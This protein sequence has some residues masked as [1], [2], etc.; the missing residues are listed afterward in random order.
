M[1]NYY[2]CA[3]A[4]GTFIVPPANAGNTQYTYNTLG[5][6][7]GVTYPDGSS[8]TFQY[9]KAGNRTQILGV[10]AAGTPNSNPICTSGSEIAL[11]RHEYSTTIY[12]YYLGLSDPDGDQVR[13]SSS[14][15]GVMT[16][17]GNIVFEGMPTDFYYRVDYTAT[18][19]RGGT[20]SG[21]FEVY[22]DSA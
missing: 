18:D 11:Y 17:A 2:L 10:S 4:I 21:Y 15:M 7:T 1:R 14:S 3:L 20:C 12:P 13:F 5:R 16:A 22:S 9:D 6:V 19:G 8:T